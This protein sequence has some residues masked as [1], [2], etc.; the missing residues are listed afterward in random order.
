VVPRGST[1]GCGMSNVLAIIMAGGRGTRLSVLSEHRAKPSVPFAAKYRIIDFTLSNCVNSGIYNIAVL[2]Q[3]RPHSLNDHIRIG[4]PWDLDRSKGGVRLLQPYE[5]ESG[6]IWYRGTADAVLQNWDFIESQHPERVLILSGDHIYKMNYQKMI[7]FH[8]RNKADLTVAVMEVPMEEASRFGIMEV[9]EKFRVV[10][11]VE[12]PK[13][14][15]SNLAS[16]G[17]YVFNTNVLRERLM[18][19][20]EENPREDF[21]KHV[22]PS[23]I[24]RDRVFAYP[25]EGYWV[26]VGTVQSYWETNLA[27][28]SSNPPLNLYDKEWVIHTRSEERPPAKIT[29]E[30]V[31]K[32]SL[33]ANGATIHG[34]VIHSVISPGVYVAHGAEVRD[35]VV[36]TDTWIGPGAVV[37]RAIIDKEVIV[38]VGAQVGVGEDFDV[39]NREQP[40]KLYTGLT[41]VGKGARIP[42]GFQ[43]GRNVLV[44]SFVVEK[45]FEGFDG[46]EVPS[47]GVVGGKGVRK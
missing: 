1:V 9:D 22:I 33:V 46:R 19:G 14:P 15:P 8:E 29:P 40:D 23:M 36:M 47:G 31:V 34:R 4:R 28:L 26:D 39:P 13:E 43:L 30:A 20:G 11:F 25:F 37:D 41:L 17:I 45:D 2:T 6:D 3:Y 12:K 32:Q 38:D 44:H 35:S 10:R 24:D 27:L 7:D 16:M 5:S 18:E 42:R 21:G